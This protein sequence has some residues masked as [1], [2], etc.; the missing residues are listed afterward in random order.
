[1]KRGS[2]FA[3]AAIIASIVVGF[4]AAPA[5]AHALLDHSDPTSGA[6]L[7]QAPANVVLTFTEDPDP[8]LSIVHVLD[9][10]GT[11]VE[12]SPARAVP[13]NP[14]Q[15]TIALPPDL[16]DG[17]YTVTWRTVS[18]KD[19]HQTASAFAFGVGVK[20]Q[21]G[22]TPSGGVV[23][24]S[25]SVA[26][27]AGKMLLYIG[28]VMLFA[29]GAMG[30]TAFGG[31]IPA[32][33]VVLALAW[34]SAAIGAVVMLTAERAMIG[35]SLHDLL[36][37]GTG[38]DYIRL[39][40][41]VAIA[42]VAALLAFHRPAVW[43]MASL[44]AATGAAM[45]VRADGGHAAASTAA[46][47]VE[48]GLQ[49]FHIMA[50]S[51]WIGGIALAWLLLRER[52]DG[53]QPL[54]EIRRFSRIAGYALAVVLVTGTLRAIDERGG[55]SAIG[56]IFAGTY[57]LTLLVKV[58][59]VLVLVGLGAWNRYRSIPRMEHDTG[60]LR[61]LMTVELVGAVG[62]FGLT[63]V[64][65]GLPPVTSVHPTAA[66]PAAISATGSDFATTVTIALTATPGTPGPNDFRAKVTDFDTGKPLDATGVMLMFQPVG[67]PNVGQS[68]LEMQN[69]TNGNWTASGTNISLAGVWGVTAVV[70]TGS[71]SASVSLTLITG[72]PDQTIGVS[73]ATG[74]PTIYTITLASGEQIQ[75]YNDPGTPGTDEWHLTA[76]D[77]DGKELPLKSVTMTAVAPDGTATAPVPRRF[78]AGHF[79]ADLQLA[80]GRWTFF[81][82]ATARDGRVLVASFDQTI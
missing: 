5:Q 48:V 23:S 43:S 63:G 56:R 46:P 28:L 37:S 14:L 20:P 39:L 69:G 3:L 4:A 61:R 24:P 80:T 62:V 42:G 70:Q 47:L 16:P 57:G 7:A 41:A 29:A 32:R 44:V 68:M 50:A 26:S 78:S 36:S 51:A 81:M 30:L 22:A 65:T 12:A 17:V 76:F 11:N 1:M 8:T 60:M 33:R 66:A 73:T 31:H 58:L 79:V 64:L 9:A 15:L 13:G 59:V 19:G 74:Q 72:T 54:K 25:P 10:N 34:L 71:T 40:V 67:N 6:E 49:W 21:P 35:V 53:E 77:P 45:L 75:A 82:Q 27:V 38:R 18:T 55:L 2:V 52:R